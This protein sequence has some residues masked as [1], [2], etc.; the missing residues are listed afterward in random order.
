MKTINGNNKLERQINKAKKYL[1]ID[2][3]EQSNKYLKIAD[4]D[5]EN[6]FIAVG[7]SWK[8]VKNGELIVIDSTNLEKAIFKKEFGCLYE[9]DSY[10]NGSFCIFKSYGE[11]EH[12][13]LKEI[14]EGCDDIWKLEDFIESKQMNFLI[15][16]K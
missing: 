4:F 15:A 2:L 10:F 6:T 5:K 11:K 8:L 14:S 12:Q 1:N 16:K 7:D 9:K 3:V 13:I